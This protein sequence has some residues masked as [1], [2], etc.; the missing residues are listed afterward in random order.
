MAAPVPLL[1]ITN[2]HLL[3]AGAVVDLMATCAAY[4][5]V[6]PYSLTR[7]DPLMDV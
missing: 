2:M 7:Y 6:L 5:I 4:R 3:Y 1:T